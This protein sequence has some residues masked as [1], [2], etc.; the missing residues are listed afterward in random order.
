MVRI[1]GSL[2]ALFV[3]LLILV[4][5]GSNFLISSD[6]KRGDLYDK[7]RNDKSFFYRIESGATA[8]IRDEGN[9]TGPP[10]ILLHGAYASVHAW[11]P[12]VDKLGD[13]FRLISFD[14]PGYGL[15]G[16]TPCGDY[17]RANM[18][19]TLDQ[20]MRLMKLE[21]AVIVGH[22]M[23]G[24]VALQ[25]ALDHPEKIR[26]L[27]LIA[28]SGMRRTS[29]E[30][31][32]STFGLADISWLQPILRYVTPR[33]IIESALRDSVADPDNFVTDEQV[34]RYWELIRMT[35][36]RE[37]ILQQQNSRDTVAPLESR[38]GEITIPTLLIWGAQDKLV[39]LALGTRMNSAIFNSRLIAY[40]DIG[41]LPMEE[42][43]ARTAAEARAFVEALAAN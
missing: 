40:S 19:R 4:L 29:D 30:E 35:D 10:L 22:S 14:L 38:L 31:V 34:T 39:P 17:S 15:T 36:S 6:L 42:A 32:P 7:Y 18:S 23:G 8:H 16:A 24:G 20:I 9:R 3:A 41:H 2:L 26:G 28:S 5:L 21:R 1:L 37:A 12:W 11:E 43:P 13:K 33:F 25:Y 27:I